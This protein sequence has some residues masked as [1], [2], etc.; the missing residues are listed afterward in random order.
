MNNNAPKL[1]KCWTHKIAF[2]IISKMLKGPNFFYSQR[3]TFPEDAPT[4]VHLSRTFGLSFT[5]S[6]VA[7]TRLSTS[8]AYLNPQI[9]NN[10]LNWVG[11]KGHLTYGQTYTAMWL[12]YQYFSYS[13]K[14]D[15]LQL[16][17]VF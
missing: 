7:P 6:S 9:G 3:S 4:K 2:N 5:I 14:S 13:N 8:Y 11:N 16:S 10:N 12:Q 1:Q 15:T 17:N